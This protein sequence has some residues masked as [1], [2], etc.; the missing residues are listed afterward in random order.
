MG[1]L[2]VHLRVRAMMEVGTLKDPGV[3]WEA[4]PEASDPIIVSLGRVRAEGPDCYVVTRYFLIGEPGLRAEVARALAARFSWEEEGEGDRDL[5]TL[6]QAVALQRVP[7]H[8]L[9]RLDEVYTYMPKG[10]PPLTG[11]LST[12]PDDPGALLI[13]G[14]RIPFWRLCLQQG[15]LEEACLT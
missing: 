4:A 12:S 1:T 6:R 15:L 5:P 2:P 14:K 11:P 7:Q 9:P 8:R 10:G 13:A 3:F